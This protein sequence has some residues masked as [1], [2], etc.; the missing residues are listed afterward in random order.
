[1][2]VKK[3]LAIEVIGDWAVVV[4]GHLGRT[5]PKKRNARSIPIRESQ[6]TEFSR[7]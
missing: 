7:V 6:I 2:W 1:V 3:P 4:A 5:L